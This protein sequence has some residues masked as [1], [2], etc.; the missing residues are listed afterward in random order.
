MDI[1][2]LWSLSSVYGDGNFVFLT[3][4]FRQISLLTHIVQQTK[5]LLLKLICYSWFHL[6]CFALTDIIHW[7]STIKWC[8]G[9]RNCFVIYLEYDPLQTPALANSYYTL[10]CKIACRRRVFIYKH[11]KVV[12]FAIFKRHKSSCNP[13]CVY[14][15]K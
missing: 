10:Y 5:A 1:V 15:K 14:K 9:K 2:F 12:R 11:K 13:N 4:M 6:I 8:R 7:L 3:N